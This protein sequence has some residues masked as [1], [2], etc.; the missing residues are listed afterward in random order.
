VKFLNLHTPGTC[1]AKGNDF[2][3]LLP[4][5]AQSAAACEQKTSNSTSSFAKEHH[6]LSVT[7]LFYMQFQLAFK[8]ERFGSFIGN[9]L[10]FLNK[11]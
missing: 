2:Q 8:E 6:H 11:N 3:R 4:N 1:F 5:C 10:I 9:Y 7:S